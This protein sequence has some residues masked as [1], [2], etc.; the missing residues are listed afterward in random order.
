MYKI[1]KYIG[2]TFLLPGL[3][4]LGFCFYNGPSAWAVDSQTFWG[5][6]ISLFVFWIGLAHAGTLLSAIFLVLDIKLDKRTAMLAELSTLCSLA[7]AV[8]FPLVHLG[9]V[10]R[11]Y[12]VVPFAD[13]RMNM[14]NIRSPLV[15]DFCCIGIYGVLSLIFFGTHLASKRF[16]G[17]AKVRKSLAWLLFPL[18]LWVHTVVSLDFAS[19]FVPQWSGAFFP[20]YFIV[21]A[22]YSGIALVCVI[23][24]FEGYRVRILEQLLRIGSW[25]ISAIWLWEFLTKGVFYSSAF[26]MAGVLP[27]LLW[28][29]AIRN[30]R[31]CRLLV[32]LSILFGLLFE[33][34]FLVSPDLGIGTN[35]GLVD[36]GLASFGLGFFIIGFCGIRWKLGAAVEGEN[37]FFGEVDDSDMNAGSDL[38]MV[39]GDENTYVEPWK[40]YETKALRFP[41]FVGIS[42]S[43]LFCVWCS[44]K[45]GFDNVDLFVAQ[46][47]PLI[48]PLAAF[49]ATLIVCIK[50]FHEHVNPFASEKSKKKMAGFGITLGVLILLA[51]FMGAVYGGGSSEPS[52]KEISAQDMTP[53]RASVDSVSMSRAN[54]I[55]NARCASCHGFDGKFNEKFVREFYPVPQKLDRARIDSLGIDSLANVV[56]KGRVNMNSYEGRLTSAEARGLILYMQSLAK[57]NEP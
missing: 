42:M 1:L 10:D 13:A 44:S 51:G 22:I 49:I 52:N 32:Y 9:V 34:L 21:G 7:I 8:V 20:L 4:A 5:T 39:A 40:S 46:M 15:W 19:A 3:V 57:E 29:S 33:R 25:L 36:F 23:L 45:V 30:S 26:V 16:E 56:L 41:I 47:I 35:F 11:F 2:L 48:Y 27:Q 14:A 55:W 12:M 54:L 24:W 37:T 53:L 28:V 18:V 31:T 43:I 50:A 6:P 38:D 17:L